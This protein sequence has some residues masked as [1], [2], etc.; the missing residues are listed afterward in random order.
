MRFLSN[1][2]V[3]VS[4]VVALTALVTMAYNKT[5]ESDTSKVNNAFYKTLIFGMAIGLPLAYLANRSSG[6]DMMNGS[7]YDDSFNNM[8]FGNN[9]NA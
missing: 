3:L 7:F 9:S 6:D 8:P 4:L 1:P 5:L 2:Y